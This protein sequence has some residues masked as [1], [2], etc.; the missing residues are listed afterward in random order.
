MPAAQPLTWRERILRATTEQYTGSESPY[1]PATFFYA[2]QH[3]VFIHRLVGKAPN[4]IDLTPSGTKT[5]LSVPAFM[6]SCQQDNRLNMAASW[7]QVGG[8]GGP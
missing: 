6:S 3:R 1:N 7:K 5:V 2:C 8:L 4:L